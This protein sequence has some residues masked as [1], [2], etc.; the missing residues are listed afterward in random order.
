[1][2]DGSCF[3]FYLAT[4]RSESLKKNFFASLCSAKNVSPK[5][6]QLKQEQSKAICQ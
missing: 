6:A 2:Q 3:F 5:T 4:E 1:L